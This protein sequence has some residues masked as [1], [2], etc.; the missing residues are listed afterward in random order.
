MDRITRFSL[1]NAAAV[2]LLVVLVTA[3]GLWSAMQLKKETMPDIAIPIVAV[4]TPYP[5]AAPGDVYDQ[6]TKPLE[7]ALRGVE[8][9]KQVSAQSNDSVSIV[10]TEFSFSQD[11]DEAEANV[12]KVLATVKLPENTIAPTVSRISFGSAPIMKLAVI[13]ENDADTAALRT[14]VRDRIIPALQGVQGVGEA[15][16]AA[17]SPE[18]IKIELDQEKLDDEGLT[19][20]GVIDQ[21]KAANLSFP[22]GTVDLGKSTEPIRVGGSIESVDDVEDFSVAVYPDQNKIMGDAFA[23]IGEGM[24]ALGSAVGAL[25]QGMGQGFSALGSGMGELGSATG[26]VA[27][28]AGMINGIQQIQSQM[29]SL[30]YDTLPQ[31]KAAASSMPTATPG[32]DEAQ[33][34]LQGQIAQIEAALPGMKAASDSLQTQVTASQKKMQAQAASVGAGGAAGGVS[35]MAGMSAPSGG[36]ASASSKSSTPKVAIGMVRLGDVAKVTYAPLDGSVGSRA[37]SKNAVLI[38]IVKTQDSNTVDISTAVETELESLSEGFPGSGAKIETVYDASTGINASVDGMLR[39]GLLGALFAVIVIMVFLRNWRATIIAAVS[40]PLSIL[41]A[42]VFL[43]QTDVTLNVMTLGGLTVAI[44][45]VV[46]DSI[47]VIENIF[48]HLQRGETP[49]SELIRKATSEVASAITTS[50]LTTVAVFLPLGLV[51]GVI[52][53]IFLPFAITVALSLL[54]SLL[55][56]I[57][58]VPLMAKWFLLKGKMPVEPTDESK[59]MALY[60]RGLAWSLGH[61]WIVV[62]AAVVMFAGSLALIPLIGTGFVPEAKE[63][64]IQV[65]VTYP[66]GTKAA[67]VDK[68]VLGIEKALSSEKDVDFYQS[69]VGG[70]STSVSMSGG[71][72][73]SNT[74][75]LYVRLGTSASMDEVIASLEK[76]TESLGSEG[77]DIAF[78]RIDASGTNSSLELIITGD[79][80]AD[81]QSASD[82]VEKA[83][84]DVP[85]LVNVKSNLG[86]ARKQ[87]VV[88]VDQAK[89]AKYGLN[90]AMVAG[91]VR[92]YVAEQKAGTIK[93]KG[94]PTDVYYVLAL[95]PLKRA[96]EMRKLELTTPLGKTIKLS[97]I[98]AVNETE[99]PVAILTRN[100][101]EFAAV[102]AR[103]TERDTGSVITAVNE[104][105]ATLDLPEGVKTET[106]GTAEQM[107][108]SF[109]QL[110]IAMII[111]IGAVYLVLMIAFGEAVAPLAIMFSLPLAVV[112]GLIGLLITDLPLDIPAM[113]GALMLIGIV[114]TNAVVLVDRVRQKQSAGMDRTSSLLEAGSTRMR[115]ILMTAIATIMALAPL[116]SGFAEGALIS[117]SLA[118]IVIGGL[119]TSTLL[120]L[121]VVPVAYDLLE[122]AKERIFGKGDHS[123]APETDPTPDGGLTPEAA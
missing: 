14:D 3:G 7:K 116:A 40:I 70:S 107:N 117:Q 81:I 10:V 74:A 95:D 103:I 2:I 39:E 77:V 106:G 6:V 68:T 16:I 45:R 100:T 63:K 13:A 52:G 22:V 33:A 84:A 102:S 89:A 56:A 47:V 120:T 44:G 29:Y 111:A 25:G 21:L 93:V 112:G 90:A 51:T 28:Q 62:A 31:L 9:I 60:R 92:G 67:E 23:Q 114:V 88:D 71:L 58:V 59:P 8:G 15:K 50:T 1:K 24:G 41:I 35:S 118:V 79:K 49:N 32:Y 61:R 30:K 26:E 66:E 38:D 5:G 101:A 48:R 69:T 80:L 85:G 99:S 78:N 105:V 97:T 53:K 11:M 27:M 119:T 72:G 123:D 19:A 46:D 55:V 104:K 87:L 54:A 98:A 115:P 94:Q 83:L 113:I 73:G 37:N 36:S 18:V 34:Q 65:D 109:S 110:G 75:A 86:V 108:E 122:G 82:T 12:N 17:D 91:T 57:T 4:V 43:K 64:Y 20:S 96:E 121:I 76:K 42:M